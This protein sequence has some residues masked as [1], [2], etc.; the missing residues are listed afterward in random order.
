[1]ASIH[2]FSQDLPFKLPKPRKVSNWI[3]STIASEE[4]QLNQLNFVFCSDEALLKLNIEYLNHT[5]LT[6]II[7][8]NT[9]DDPAWIEGEIYISIDRVRE[10]A[11]RLENTFIDELHRV[12]I[13]GV[14]HLLGYGDKT[15][16]EKKQM[17]K[18]E[19]AY[20]SLREIN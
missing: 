19:D 7:T 4:G 6:D 16:A 15:V 3:K 5:T 13:H 8:F 18:K 1:M 12:I 17:R 9:S 10:N 2:F 14:L 11:E 20:L